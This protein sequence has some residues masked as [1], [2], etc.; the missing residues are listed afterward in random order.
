MVGALWPRRDCDTMNACG[1]SDASEVDTAMNPV[2]RTT[3]HIY[4][5]IY[6]CICV[7]I[8]IYIYTYI[9]YTISYYVIVHY[10]I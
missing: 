5:Y 2:R 9:C 8:Y 7:Y 3:I 1:H 10:I 6:I 4:I